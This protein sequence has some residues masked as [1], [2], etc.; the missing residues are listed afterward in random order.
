MPQLELRQ[1]FQTHHMRGTAIELSNRQN[2]GWA[3]AQNAT[4]I[5]EITY[6]SADVRKAM[7]AISTAHAGKSVVMIGQRGSGKSHIM[8]LTHYAFE[9]PDAVEGWAHD[10]GHR[11]ASPKLADI[12]LQRGFKAISETLSNAEF[13]VLWDVL[14]DRH[15]KGAY[16]RG[17][18]E[19]SGT[20][21]P[22]KS[23]LQD[24][25]SEQKTAL[26]L[27]EL[28]TW[29]DG[30]HDEPGPEGRKLL[31]WAFNFIQILSEIA[32][33][34]PDLFSLIVS[35]RDNTTNAF[36]Q[37]HRKSPVII[38][39]KGETARDD[40][41]RLV[42][43]RL[44]KN[45]SNIPSGSIQQAV[46]VYAGERNR[47]L[48]SERSAADQ[49]KLAEDCQECW[50]YSPE[51]MSLLEDQI[52]M[53]AAAQDSRDF[54]RMLAEVYRARGASG[55]IIT[56]ADFSVDD[57]ECG[58]TTLIDSF[59]T[60]ADQEQLRDKA[61]RNLQALKEANVNAPH[62][63]DV[64]S[65]IWVRSLSSLQSAGATRKEI[66]L[67]LTKSQAVDDN[68][69]TAEL[70][71]IVG[72]SFNIHEHGSH[73]KRYYFRLPENPES[74]LKA[75]ARNDR[76]FDSQTA[77]A[78]GL[79]AIG[80]DQDFLCKF[81]NHYLKSP[82]LS[83]ELPSQVVVLDLNWRTAPWANVPQQEQPQAWTDKGRPVLIVLPS[84]PIDV[85]GTLG[86]WLAD[87]VPQ[88]RNMV[89][90]LLPRADQPEL[91]LDK[92]LLLAAR[93][94]LLAKEWQESEPQYR[95]LKKKFD[96]ALRSEL[97]NKFDRYA[98]LSTWN[99]QFPAACTFHVEAHGASGPD[100]PA[101]VEKHVR[102]NYFAPEDF[103]KTVLDL[104]S[105][106]ETVRQLLTA[107]R[108][109]P[110]PGQDAIPYLGDIQIFE[111]LYKIVANGNLALNA[112]GRW[113]AREA[114]ETPEAAEN[115]LRARLGAYSSGTAMLSVQLGDVTQI[116]SGGVAIPAPPQPAPTPAPQPIFQPSPQSPLPSEG[117]AS[118]PVPTSP[119]SGPLIP[120]PA[121]LPPQPAIR[122]SNG[123]K[124]GMNLLGDIEKWA[125]T[126]NRKTSQVML[127]F[128][129]LT[130][131]EVRDLCVKLPAK[132]QAELQMILP[133]E[134]GDGA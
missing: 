36:Q 28:Q 128:N 118:S 26:I 54:I 94:A 19:Q 2:T 34:R 77:S 90:F 32:G 93:C 83:R 72:N 58:V 45:R 56:P 35:V 96:D 22:S 104:A 75:W 31:S 67:D 16:Y 112:G 130:V 120:P 8:A 92:G 127:T 15:P 116:G 86:P 4:A 43:H 1:E 25:F 48:F 125:F 12:S 21:I 3:Q 17:R 11:L 5:L 62:M 47:L 97:K 18:F 61:I 121:P 46:A 20:L 64:I 91:Y 63:R 73:E 50:P 37:L 81:L 57:D 88:N 41:K 59:A 71:E 66:Q 134:E 103:K 115:R 44:F 119:V 113:Y 38:D 30:L 29:Y 52:L 55:S 70:A 51:L 65:S 87:H 117:S 101:S 49:A 126:D 99:F 129:G 13:P 14:F 53:A 102:E 108:E 110:L 60:T 123:A 69:F 42:L 39:F 100:I 24:M 98:I 23:L 33:E 76:A 95:D 84:S 6:P 10:W 79:M 114:G 85:A 82:D 124:T 111:S 109:A 131:K 107:L 89:R 68:A 106:N 27:D 74:K 133:F 7:D 40:R 132:L 78:P 105:R 122:K 80:K 9:T